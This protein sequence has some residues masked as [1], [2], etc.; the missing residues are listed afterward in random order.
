[1]APSETA[2][3]SDTKNLSTNGAKVETL[4]PLQ[5]KDT[6][7]IPLHVLDQSLNS[8]LVDRYGGALVTKSP[9]KRERKKYGKNLDSRSG[10]ENLLDEYCNEKKAKF[11]SEEYRQFR[12]EQFQRC[13]DFLKNKG[14]TI[15]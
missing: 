14:I 11:A 15:Y 7:S 3:N 6:E 9:L 2:R 1:M 10:I 8:S 12:R 5:T 4:L 13:A